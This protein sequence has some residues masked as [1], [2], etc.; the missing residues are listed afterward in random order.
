MITVVGAVRACLLK[1]TADAEE[2]MSWPYM[3]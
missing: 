3:K 1:P 2:P